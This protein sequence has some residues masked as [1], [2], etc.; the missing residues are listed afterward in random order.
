MGE[1]SMVRRVMV[2]GVQRWMRRRYRRG[3]DTWKRFVESDR[4]QRSMAEKMELMDAKKK[5]MELQ[6][7]QLV[8]RSVLRH[9]VYRSEKQC[10]QQW[11]MVVSEQKREEDASTLEALGSKQAQLVEQLQRDMSMNVEMLNK[12][13]EKRATETTS[14]HRRTLAMRTIKLARHR[15]EKGR[16]RVLRMHLTGWRRVVGLG[17]GERRRKQL[18]VQAKGIVVDGEEKR[19]RRGL[20]RMDRV[21]KKIIFK[22]KYRC[23]EGWQ[24]IP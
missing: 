11:C 20:E 13:H 7:Q 17:V 15:K 24:E 22:T 16:F 18:E 23:F 10:L 21:R 5:E 12:E 8:L 19:R 4:H 3:M 1:R 2:V 6:L 14:S 9:L